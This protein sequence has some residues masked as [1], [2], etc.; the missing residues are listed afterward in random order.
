MGKNKRRQ[1]EYF[2]RI[3]NVQLGLDSNEEQDTFEWLTEA[4]QLGIIN[5]FEYQPEPYQL[6][7]STKYIAAD[8]KQR[9]LFREHIYT[10]DFKIKLDP[11]KWPALSKELKVSYE[12]MAHKQV[13]VVIDT[14]GTFNI[15]E[16]AFGLNQ[17]W[18]YQ[19]YG[20]YV[21]KLV[22]KMFFQKFGCP[23]ASFYTS[24]KKQR[25]KM[26]SGCHSI[27]EMLKASANN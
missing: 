6:S 22:P 24:K 27:E 20:I 2:D 15:T 3:H 21:Y 12:K 8:G 1:I 5:D 9:V 14:K 17:K 16:R 7:E 13:E 25:R 19:R 11:N 10:A 26:F 23:K 18:M 4:V